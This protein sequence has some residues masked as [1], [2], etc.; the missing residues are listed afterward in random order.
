LEPTATASNP[1]QEFVHGP[2]TDAA[3]STLADEPASKLLQT[4]SPLR[5]KDAI[6][7]ACA[8]AGTVAKSSAE[9]PAIII[10]LILTHFIF[11]LLACGLL[12]VFAFAAVLGTAPICSRAADPTAAQERD[13]PPVL[14]PHG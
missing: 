10:N 12:F 7:G 1:A 8:K 5:E 11:V 2:E 6:T 14:Q 4:N 9:A 3:H 13:W